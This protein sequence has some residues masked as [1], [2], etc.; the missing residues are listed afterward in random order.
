MTKV[1]SQKGDWE[2]STRNVTQ[3]THRLFKHI[4]FS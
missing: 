2:G 4:A 3:N 1:R